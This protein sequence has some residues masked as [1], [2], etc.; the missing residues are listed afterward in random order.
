MIERRVRS[1]ATGKPND[2]EKI[3]TCA[4][5]A[6]DGK[7]V[8]VFARRAY[9]LGYIFRRYAHVTTRHRAAQP[10]AQHGVDQHSITEPVAPARIP[11]QVRRA[12]HRLC[13]AGD[14]QIR[15]PLLFVYPP[16]IPAGE[17]IAQPVSLLDVAV[18]TTSILFPNEPPLFPGNSIAALW[19]EEG[20][21]Q[22]PPVVVAQ[23][24]WRDGLPKR[25]PLHRG[26]MTALIT[27]EWHFITQENGP[28]ELYRARDSDET[29]NLADTA[30]GKQ[31]VQSFQQ[32]S[33]TAP[34]RR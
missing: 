6:L 21:P 32:H 7:R 1:R 27:P 22:P 2:Q 16:A 11:G 18:T 30:D 9:Q 20:K 25:W 33:G 28:T 10:F 24:D 13:S 15:V 17:R 23:A 34:P 31:I 4:A 14:N 3:R 12:A 19:T 5:V 26:E 29:E 8:L